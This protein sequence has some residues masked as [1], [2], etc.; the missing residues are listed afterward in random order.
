MDRIEVDVI[1]GKRTV[2]PL[3]PEEVSDAQA[4]TAAENAKRAQEAAKKARE[5]LRKSRLQM[6]L[7]KLE[8]DPTIIDRL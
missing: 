7:D 6:L 3:T 1:T 8:A 5:D 2:I 4:R